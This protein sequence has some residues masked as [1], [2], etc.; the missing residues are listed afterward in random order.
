MADKKKK[1]VADL[2]AEPWRVEQLNTTPQSAPLYLAS[3]YQCDSPDQAR[4]L[5]KGQKPGYVY[6]RDGN[7]NSDILAER[8]QRLHQADWA[9]ATSSGMSALSAALLA[10]CK[11][12]DHVI[13]SRD[14]YGRTLDLLVSETTRLG[15]GS[16]AVDACDLQ[17]VQDALRPE[18]KLLVVETISNPTLKLCD[19]KQLAEMVHANGTL[20]L[21]DNTFA[22]PTVCRPLESGADL[23]V[24]SLTKIMNGHSDGILGMLAGNGDHFNRVNQVISI[25]GTSASAF[26]CW[27]T[28]R[29]LSTLHLRAERA[30]ENALKLA[31]HLSGCSQIEQV[32]YP[33][34]AKH[35]QHALAQQQFGQQFGSIV[36]FTL[37][38]E[39]IAPEEAATRFI[40]A[41]KEIPFCPSL[42]ELSTT[43]SHPAS[44]SHRNLSEAELSQ[45]GISGA[46]I[47]LS[48]GTETIE[49][50]ISVFDEALK[51]VE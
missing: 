42:G 38:A 24:E 1:S 12:G 45:L 8:C 34:L 17:Q 20:L 36:T 43:L 4:Q 5:L 31:E 27:M 51:S 47:R 10:F 16:T 49:H 30:S 21:V 11:T 32:L 44:T 35:S 26:D 23:V 25:W 2:C 37:K 18:T 6:Q 41:A 40:A 33:G 15:I 9:V 7:P 28:A 48:V 46:T 3:V 19:L 50:L 39:G 13:V 29:G 14:L 22:S